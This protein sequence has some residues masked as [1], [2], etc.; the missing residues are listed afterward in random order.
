MDIRIG[1]LILANIDLGKLGFYRKIATYRLAWI[2]I[3][4]GGFGFLLFND[5]ICRLS[6]RAFLPSEV[7]GT[8][9]AA[10][11]WGQTVVMEVGSDMVTKIDGETFDERIPRTIAKCG[12]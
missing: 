8:S 3:S 12:G 1:F 9:N 11:Q 10:A 5:F 7:A 6:Q 4:N 2:G